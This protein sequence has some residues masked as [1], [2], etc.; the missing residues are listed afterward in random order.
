[1]SDARRGFAVEVVRTLRGAGFRAFFAGG[2]VRDLLLGQDPAD[3]DVATDAHP[4]SVL[5]LFRRTVPVGV[6]F[7]VVRVLGP[8]E[9]GEVE[10]A[11]FRSDGA[12][13]DGRHPEAVHFGTAEADASRRDFTINGMFLDPEADEVIDY[14]GGRADLAAGVIRAI[15]VPE[16]RF[17]EDKLRLL[18]AVRFAARF[19]FSLEPHTREAL[20]TMAGEVVQVA[21]ERIAQEFRKMLVH[22]GRV[23]ALNLAMDSGLIAAILPELLPMKGLAQDKPLL[24]GGD[25][26]DHT[27]LAL[28]NLPP[29]PTFPLALAT[30][31]HD[32]GKP[33]SKGLK[34][35]QTTFFNHEYAGRR[36][37]ETIARRLKLSNADRDRVA[38]LVESHQA[39]ADP[40]KLREAK[41]KRL[42]TMPGIDE[43]L[44][45]HRAD[46]MASLGEAPHVDYCEWYLR[47]QPAGPI[48][49]PPLVT[50]HDL[51]QNGWTPGPRFAAMLEN[52]REAQLEGMVKS[53]KDALEWLDREEGR[54][55]ASRSAET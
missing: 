53:K 29:A 45:L 14:V 47:E 21:A 1:M 44:A 26:W 18:R 31:L 33:A 2:C 20:E 22:P 5:A 35:G 13:L 28:E 19:G 11:T 50:G 39:L 10:V 25:L 46:A 38:W 42:L 52:V 8:K 7:G 3:F 23:L 32:A 40:T 24:P 27:L 55:E 9:G 16:D 51:V 15:G 6:S 12:Y 30:L 4:E 48:N 43:L 41:L 34:D 37:A 54:D 17:R 49:P 36:I